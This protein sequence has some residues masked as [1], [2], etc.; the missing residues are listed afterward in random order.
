MS[1][2]LSISAK[3]TPIGVDFRPIC[4]SLLHRLI[5]FTEQHYY[6]ENTKAFIDSVLRPQ[7]TGEIIVF[8]GDSDELVG[9]TRIYQQQQLNSKGKLITMYFSNTYNNQTHDTR[10]AA[11][12]LALTQTMK[13]KL[14]HPKEELVHFSFVSTP[15]KYQFLARLS[16]TIYPSLGNEVPQSILSLVNE[17]KDTNNWSSCANHPMLISGQLRKKNQPVSETIARDLLSNYYLSLNPDYTLGRALLVCIPLNLSNIGYSI[18]QLVTQTF[19]H[20]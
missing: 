5:Q 14:S 20:A 8:Y 18:R 15:S 10:F 17:L 3:I 4:T 13:Y 16:N 2:S 11:A 12:K 9:Y 19:D 7:Q 6:I 1:S